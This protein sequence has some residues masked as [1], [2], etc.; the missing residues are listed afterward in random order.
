MFCERENTANATSCQIGLGRIDLA[1]QY[2][3]C[4]RAHLRDNYM[5]TRSRLLCF[6]APRM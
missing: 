6:L 2:P 3:F 1:V 5:E 4:N